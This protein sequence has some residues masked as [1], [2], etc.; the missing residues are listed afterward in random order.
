MSEFWSTPPLV[1]HASLCLDSFEQLFN[2]FLVPQGSAEARA[3]ALWEAPFFVVSHGTE[4]GALFNFAS[5][6]S[7]LLW[8]M[9][10]H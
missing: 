2:R 5:V 6:E 7:L 8:E 4:D 9:S 1:A 10:W 3:R